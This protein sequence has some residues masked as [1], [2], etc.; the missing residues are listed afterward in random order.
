LRTIEQKDINEICDETLILGDIARKAMEQVYDVVYGILVDEIE[1]EKAEEI[2]RAF[3][4]GRRTHDYPIRYEE[5]KAMDLPVR[6]DLPDEIYRLMELYPQPAKGRP[7]VQY[8]PIP[9]R[10]L[11]PPRGGK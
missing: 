8:V 2:A 1:P 6:S 4:E 10:E 9:Y 3:T 11:P 5:L 7:S